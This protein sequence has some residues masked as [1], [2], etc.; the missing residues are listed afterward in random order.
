LERPAAPDGHLAVAFADRSIGPTWRAG[1]T[2]HLGWTASTIK[3]AIATDLLARS[4]PT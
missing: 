2:G 3:L 4:R 1:E